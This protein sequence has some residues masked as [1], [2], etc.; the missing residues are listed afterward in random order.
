[1]RTI[2][3]EVLLKSSADLCG[4][5]AE[6][7]SGEDFGILRRAHSRALA[8]I[9]EFEEWPDLMRVEKRYFRSLYTAG[10]TYTA[11]TLT[12]VNEVYFPQTSKHYQAL[13]NMALAVTSITRSS[14]TATVTTTAPHLLVTG[15]QVSVSGANQTD[16]NITATITVTGADTFTYTVANAPT[17][18]ATGTILVSPDPAD[19]N[20][21]TQG[22][23]WADSELCYTGDAWLNTETN[24]LGDIR[25][26]PGTDR[27]YVYYNST[28]SAGN[29]PTNTTYWRVLTEFDRYIA[30]AQTG[31]TDLSGAT[32]VGVWSLEPRNR[33]RGHEV[34][35]VLTSNGINVPSNLAYVWVE[36][37][38][39]PPQLKGEVYSETPTYASGDQVYFGS[40]STPGNFYDANTT[41]SAG[42]DP[43][44]TAAK[45]DVVQIPYDFE[46][47]LVHQGYA[48]W[49]RQDGQTDKADFADREAEGYLFAQQEKLRGTQNQ[50]HRTVV[51]AR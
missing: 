51:K 7:I 6:E 43:D 39:K 13:R 25:Y 37:R 15:N 19:A 38:Q 30:W 8:T 46:R 36:Y 33:T 2:A 28:D 31:E 5:V 50:R 34:D 22:V 42:E 10:T 3:Y 32:I 1:M 4:L 9:W 41:T 29:Q 23:Y 44:D 40:T 17:T 16:Y 47:Y 14:S 27:F 21:E 35:F 12:A 49:L 45:W 24:T 11:A 20:D 18:P 48:D 26:W